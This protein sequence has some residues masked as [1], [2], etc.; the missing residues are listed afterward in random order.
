MSDRMVDHA[1]RYME[2]GWSVIP[3]I[4]GSKRPNIEWRPYIEQ[5]ADRGQIEAWWKATPTANIGLVTGPISGVC[6]VDVDNADPRIIYEENP[7]NLV[8]RTPKGW[9]LV[10]RHPGHPVLTRAGVVTGVDVRGDGG[11]I[12]AAPSV[13]D[14]REYR[15]IR[16]A[17][18]GAL[19]DPPRFVQGDTRPYTERPEIVGPQKTSPE[20]W[21]AEVFEGAV[22]GMRNQ[23]AAKLAGYLASKDVPADVT[24]QI[25]KAWNKGT[26]QNPETMPDKEIERTVKSIYDKAKRTPKLEDPTQGQFNTIPIEEYTR[27]YSNHETKWIIEDWL[28]LDTIAFIVSPP[29]SFKTWILLDAMLSIA[30]GKRFLGKWE[31]AKTGPVVLIQQEDNHSAIVNRINTVLWSKMNLGERSSKQ[32][33]FSAAV[34]PPGIPAHIYP[35]RMLRFD[36]PTV[37]ESFR[38][39]IRKIKPVAVFIDPLYTTV[40]LDNYMTKAAEQMMFLKALRDEVGCSFVIAHHTTKGNPEERKKP[41]DDENPDRLD[42]WG[43]QFLNAFLE[44]GWQIRRTPAPNIIKIRRHFKDSGDPGEI[45]LEMDVTEEKVEAKPNKEHVSRSARDQYEEI[46][47][48]LAMNGPTSINGIATK[49]KRSRNTVRS[50][51][52]VLEGTGDVVKNNE[53]QCW[54]AVSIKDSDGTFSVQNSLRLDK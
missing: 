29:G 22:E 35:D 19:S 36:N 50:A 44:T 21:I 31:V 33:E 48:F 4:P 51:L 53:T 30:T 7:C 38:N 11:Y 40:S 13:V 15:W 42:I 24:S 32:D 26:N 17:S 8:Q 45:A 27:R 41:K 34:V 10:Y 47:A 37:V 1:L 49:L 3:L 2:Q 14:G 52:K 18:L 39:T 54:A 28:P 25:L 5:R 16:E 46:I 23:S 9:H 6:V 12:V 20:R 43:S